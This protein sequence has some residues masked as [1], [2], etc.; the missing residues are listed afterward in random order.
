MLDPIGMYT[1]LAA[2][3]SFGVLCGLLVVQWRIKPLGLSLFLA[4][5]LSA[6]WALTVALVAGTS[7]EIPGLVALTE[8]SRNT[9]WLFVLLQMLGLQIDGDRWT[10]RGKPWRPIF[11]VVLVA[12]LVWTGPAPLLLPLSAESTLHDDGVAVLWLCLALAGLLV[13][14][15]LFRNATSSERWSIK[16]LCL[17]LGALLAYDFYMYAETLLWREMDQ[18]LWRARGLV[19]AIVPPLL[20]V[21]IAR[22]RNWRVR[23]HVSRQVV[24]HTVTLVGAGLF[25]LGMGL[26]GYFIRYMG[27]SWGPVLQLVFL[28]AAALLLLSLLFS[29]K[30]RAHLRV[31][32]SKH[33]FSYRYDYRNEWLAFTRA[34]AGLNQDVPEGIIRIMAALASSPAG[35][36][37]GGPADRPMNLLAHWQMPPPAGA[38]TGLGEL[39]AWLQHK[40]W[41]IDLAEWRRAPDLYGTCPLPEWLRGNESL[42]LIVPLEFRDRVE[43]VLMLKQSALKK[44]INWEDRDLLKTAGRQ[45]ATHLAQHLASKA[46]LESRQFNAFNRLSAY[47][48]HDLKNIL[49]QQSL[50]VSNA[51]RH[52]DN[53]AFVDDMIGTVE[54]SVA[55]MRR[56]ME[57]MRNGTR[58]ACAQQLSLLPLLRQVVDSRGHLRPVPETDFPEQGCRLHAD[59]ERLATV[60]THL[61]Q[62][63]Q[64]ATDPD[65][66]VRVTLSID[67]DRASVAISDSGR[68]MDENFLREQLF[69]PFQSTKGLTG[70]GIGAFESREYIRQLGGEISVTSVPGQGSCF[71]VTIP[72]CRPDPD[73]DLHRP[74]ESVVEA[75]V[76]NGKARQVT[77]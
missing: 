68:G 3:L 54:N 73:S 21:A 56:L 9:A 38:E 40:G 17:G 19:N 59:P 51:A 77:P 18:Q 33:F 49:A 31:L 23:L 67:G 6:L 1:Y 71:L 22:N 66:R 65:G 4:C 39:P 36:L 57:Q 72:G 70:M 58:Q 24:F 52:R 47:V 75:A 46:L 28:A 63:A 74:D 26:A 13:I 62:N 37:W 55:R 10:L 45:A 14:E 41:V 30:L 60:F 50:I 15:Q 53:P 76:L 8:L 48:V 35:L 2:G 69:Q 43:A 61:I 20:A 44:S 64:E 11:F 12:G 42:W 27:G 29:G 32:L 7:I 5:T 16:Y 25:L 34:L